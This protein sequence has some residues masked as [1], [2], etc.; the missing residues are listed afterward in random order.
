MF[1]FVL[2]KRTI[3]GPPPSETLDIVL[4]VF[5]ALLAVLGVLGNCIAVSLNTY[6]ASNIE[7]NL[8]NAQGGNG[9]VE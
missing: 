1:D 8:S 2:L 3:S 6:T 7:K 4:G 9:E 5:V